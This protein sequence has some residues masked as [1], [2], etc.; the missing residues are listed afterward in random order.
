MTLQ[1][2]IHPKRNP[3][4]SSGLL[5]FGFAALLV[6]GCAS[7]QREAQSPETEPD[8]AGG[9]HTTNPNPSN[10]AL[11]QAERSAL[12][13]QP[14][15]FPA[16]VDFDVNGDQEVTEVEF[17]SA[18][19]QQ[20]ILVDWDTDRSETLSTREFGAE[21]YAAWDINGDGSVDVE[22]FENGAGVYFPEANAMGTFEDY[23][24]DGDRELTLVEFQDASDEVHADWDGDSDGELTDKEFESSLYE[25]WDLNGDGVIDHYEL[26]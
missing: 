3:F 14:Q 23:D 2:S 26:K 1:R 17:H 12:V 9:I 16:F 11:D 19:H 8:Q 4:G 5:T 22:E 21:F 15:V 24:G 13:H 20:A 18:L 6:A 7:E 10:A 25:A